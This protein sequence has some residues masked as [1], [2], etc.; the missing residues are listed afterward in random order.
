VADPPVRLAVRLTV[1]AGWT[2]VAASA[3]VLACVQDAS[4]AP[5]RT[6]LVLRTGRVDGEPGVDELA[7][8]VVDRVRRLAPDTVRLGTE[9]RRVSGRTAIL[10]VL[11]VP[12]PAHTLSVVQ[13]QTVL[14]WPSTVD[15]LVQVHLTCR[16]DRWPELAPVLHAVLDS[17]VIGAS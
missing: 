9:V 6:N 5:A 8:A 17:I 1:P 12:V 7:A 2:T 13:A 3:E 10:T 4:A 16:E 15:H 14:T 11:R